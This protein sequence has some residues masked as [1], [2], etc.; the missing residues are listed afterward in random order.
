MARV[1]PLP[2]IVS[3][4]DEEPWTI[5]EL[6]AGEV[7]SVSFNKRVMRVPL[8]DTDHEHDTRLHEMAHVTWSKEELLARVRDE[9][10]CSELL[11]QGVEDARI[12]TNLRN[13]GL[14]L[15]SQVLQA[16]Q[17]RALGNQKPEIQVAALL[18]TRATGDEQ[19]LREVLPDEIE[20]MVDA[21]LDIAG[22][23]DEPGQIIEEQAIFDAL[24]LL[25]NPGS[26]GSGNGTESEE[27]E[28][29]EGYDDE[30]GDP[31]PY[32]SPRDYS[33]PEERDY[34]EDGD[35]YDGDSE[36]W[37]E[38]PVAAD[39]QQLQEALASQAEQN[40]GIRPIPEHKLAPGSSDGGANVKHGLKRPL[41]ETPQYGGW[42]Q[43]DIREPARP[44]R[45]PARVRGRGKGVND[46]GAVPVALHRSTS[47]GRIFRATRIKPVAGTVLIDNSGSMGFKLPDLIEIMA[48]LPASTI[49][50]YCSASEH[51]ELRILAREGRMVSE[52]VL[53][54]SIGGNNGVDGPAL[55]WLVQQQGPRFWVSDGG[56]TGIQDEY[57]NN[58]PEECLV[59]CKAGKVIQIPSISEMRTLLRSGKLNLRRHPVIKEEDK[60]SYQ[61]QD[62]R[63]GWLS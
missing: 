21:A 61:I 18:A 47:D 58:G 57:N 20:A 30:D 17:L 10:G 5:E 41:T 25:T 32:G 3:G 43:M 55:R 14:E 39:I 26:N 33:E 49:A 53:A 15:K 51:G 54:T 24:R 37:D 8:G 23:T 4:P 44:H 35:G 7:A 45:L 11:V 62:Y 9:I 38:Q 1:I 28:D 31:E 19:P 12:N 63:G 40:D 56:V 13:I 34:D 29:E 59:L 46:T 6:K 36:E 48:A 16:G 2:G 42:A 50:D 27:G 60:P 52:K 22:W